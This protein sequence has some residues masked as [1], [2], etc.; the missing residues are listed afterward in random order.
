MVGSLTPISL[1][2]V[3]LIKYHLTCTRLS[4][5]SLHSLYLQSRYLFRTCEYHILGNHLFENYKALCF[6]GIFFAGKEA[7]KWNERGFEGLKEQI[8]E[9]ILVDGGHFELSPMY[10][11]IILEGLLDIQVLFSAY[12]MIERFSVA[13]TSGTYV[14]LVG[15]NAA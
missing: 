1:R 13:A 7:E 15:C 5:E 14:V 12:T 2:I 10:H 4:E 11:C 8:S 9:Q 6:A 3:N